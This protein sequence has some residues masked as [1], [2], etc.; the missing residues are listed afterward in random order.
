MKRLALIPS[1]FLLFLLNSDLLAQGTSFRVNVMTEKGLPIEF[2][3]VGVPGTNIGTMTNEFGLAVLYSETPIRTIRV[4][5]IGFQAVDTTL[6]GVSD[7]MRVVLKEA[8]YQLPEPTIQATKLKRVSYGLDK[9]RTRLY[10]NFAI[11]GKPRQNL[12][13]AMGKIVDFGNETH[14]LDRFRVFL[15]GCTFDTVWLRLT[16]FRAEGHEPG[17]PIL[18]EGIILPV[19]AIRSG[20]VNVSIKERQIQLNG[21]VFFCLEWVGYSGKAGF[22]SVPLSMPRPFSNHYYRYGSQNNWKRHRLMSTSMVI[23]AWKSDE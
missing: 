21:E 8:R 1:L 19:S 15:A 4:S 9:E 10:T 11:S 23:D 2:V 18:A 16:I 17:E 12:G 14:I 3:A 5:C 6:N 20:W 7:T 22:L 13:A